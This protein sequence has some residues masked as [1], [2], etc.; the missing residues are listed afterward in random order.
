MKSL[1]L[2]CLLPFCAR[3]ELTPADFAYGLPLDV[4]DAAPAYELELPEAVYRGVRR[5][6]L[7]DLRVFNAAG[8]V[9]PHDLY[10]P[11]AQVATTTVTLPLFPLPQATGSDNSPLSLRLDHGGAGQTLELTLPAAAGGPAV[12]RYLLDASALTEPVQSLQL[13]WAT[14]TDTLYRADLTVS[15]DLR[16]WRPLVTDAG[17]ADLAF[18]GQRLQ[19]L[20]LEFPASSARYFLLTLHGEPKPPLTGVTAEQLPRHVP[21]PL[22][23][24]GV[25]VT[26]GEQAGEYRFDHPGVFE[27][28][29]LRVELPQDNT[30]SPLTVLARTQAERAA[31]QV[32]GSER[33]Y[34]LRVRGVLLS[35]E[36][37]PI[38]PSHDRQWLL[39]LSP[40]LG[41]GVP[42]VTLG[43]RPHTLV[44]L[45]RGDG[46][47]LLAY[48][49]ADAKP[50][51]TAAHTL[52]TELGRGSD[53]SLVS[54]AV[55]LGAAVELSGEQALAERL[56]V[57]WKRLLLWATLLIGVGFLA[58]MARG[59]WREMGTSRP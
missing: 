56:E 37:L 14:D 10:Q 18:G 41:K 8:E 46:P 47:Y 54:R 24:S 32:L 28:V 2:L 52:L 15:D 48:G 34:R 13:G 20:A 27:V 53:T 4:Q 3:A 30:L 49:S 38:H 40:D 43:W 16:G 29:S 21:P 35:D 57:D 6:D 23:W 12:W 31:W 51:S 9:V 39:R 36:E 33:L 17:I 7:G 55:T 50:A 19:Q 22:R 26:A 59:L 25:P 58:W 45:A 1:W 44:F 5:A 11:A 42:T